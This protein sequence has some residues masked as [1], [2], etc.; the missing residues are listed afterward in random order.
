MY[1][2]TRQV[3][4]K[5]AHTR[6]GMA[7]ALE[8]LTYVNQKT[9]LQVSLFQ[10]LQGAPLGTLTFA[11]RTDSY[12]ASVEATD[13]LTRSDEYLKKVESGAAFFVG[14]PEDRLATF[15]HSAG[16]VSAP[17]AAAAVVSA[18]LEVSKIAA[19]VAW[20]VELGDYLTNATGV[21]SAVLTSNVGPY[22]TISWLN[23]GT[24]LLQLE[25]ANAKT[26]ADPGFLRRL[27]ESAGFFV[28]GS[29]V[30]VLSRK[31]G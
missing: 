31:I 18:R 8:M 16:E 14:N 19:A 15:I 25:K 3:V 30:G 5:A 13:A 2:F 11:Y 10:V 24:S 28:P 9:K 6:A 27:G 26:S 1:L 22:G 21:P 4:V 29:G 20:A 7:H 23:Y 12:A 17:P